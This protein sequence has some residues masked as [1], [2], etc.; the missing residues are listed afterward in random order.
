MYGK[1]AGGASRVELKKVEYKPISVK[2]LLVQMSKFSSLMVDLAYTAY[3]YNKKSLAEEVMKLEEQV[4]YLSYLLLMNASLAVRDK[5]DAEMIAGILKMASAVD[6]I[7]NAAADIANLVL[8][9]ISSHDLVD[10][11]FELT[12]ETVDALEI[13]N[14]GFIGK[15]LEELSFESKLGVNVIAVRKGKKWIIDPSPDTKLEKGDIIIVRGTIDSV[16]H[17]ERVFG[18]YE[19]VISEEEMKPEW[20][21]ISTLVEDLK[22]INEIMIYLAYSA[23]MF[24]NHRLAKEVLELEEYTDKLHTEYELEVLKLHDKLSKNEKTI[25]GL[26][27]LGIAAENMADAAAMMAEITLRGLEPHPIIRDIINESEE[28]IIAV[29]VG[30]HSDVANKKLI[31]TNLEDSGAIVL[32]VRRGKKWYFKPTEEFIFHPDDILILKIFPEMKTT[33]KRLVKGASPKEK[34]VQ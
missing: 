5:E 4:D 10:Y 25:V 29:R 26:L 23:L 15:T 28:L 31:D 33:I 6:G 17:M 32:A 9:G 3:L 18:V 16:D 2:E 14:T 34:A 19:E 22:D 7:S 12:Y 24:H 13:K 20:K 8:L 1:Y 30:E 21:K 11:A 27:R